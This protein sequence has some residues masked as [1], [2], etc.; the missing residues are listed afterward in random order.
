MFL[1]QL[2]ESRA[3]ALRRFTGKQ[4]AAFGFFKQFPNNPKLI[5]P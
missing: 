5:A 2:D 1:I 4:N 3:N